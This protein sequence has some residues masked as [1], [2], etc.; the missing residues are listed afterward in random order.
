ALRVLLSS[1][2]ALR[3]S[4]FALPFLLFA[5]RPFAL[6]FLSGLLARDAFELALVGN[7]AMAVGQD[8]VAGVEPG[9]ELHPVAPLGAQGD[10]CL[11]DFAVLQPVDVVLALQREDRL[12]RDGGQ[13]GARRRADLRRD[14]HARLQ[15]PVAVRQPDLSGDRARVGARAGADDAH[16]AVE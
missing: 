10:L 7:G 4:R 13:Y 12:H 2:L 11:A 8:P 6:L 1:L 3:P 9:Q 14:R 5:L 15:P 16:G